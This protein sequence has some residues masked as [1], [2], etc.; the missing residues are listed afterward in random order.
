MRAVSPHPAVLPCRGR[1]RVRRAGGPG[2]GCAQLELGG[3]GRRAPEALGGAELSRLAPRRTVAAS[4]ARTQPA[5]PHP[6]R[7]AGQL[8]PADKGRTILDLK[9]ARNYLPRGGSS[10]P[11]WGSP[12]EAGPDNP[13]GCRPAVPQRARAGGRWLGAP[14]PRP[15]TQPLPGPAAGA[16]PPA[17]SVLI[18]NLRPQPLVPLCPLCPLVSVWAAGQTP[19]PRGP[20]QATL[21]SHT[22][23]AG[24]SKIR[25]PRVAAGSG[26]EG[27]FWLVDGH[28]VCPHLAKRRSSGL[29][30][31]EGH[32]S[33]PEAPRS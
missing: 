24:K 18:V 1:D 19:R 7:R 11:P 27:L 22:P 17:T 26:G 2:Q 14:G 20:K 21:T 9:N 28:L 6:A 33:H 4:P 29:F 12:A 23:G 13:S 16:A 8:R 32:C 5:G 31:L 10:G 3:P 30:L 15:T 25:V